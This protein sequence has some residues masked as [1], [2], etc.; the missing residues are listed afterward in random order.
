VGKVEEVKQSASRYRSKKK[1][2]HEK[3]KSNMPKS[4][5][6]LPDSGQKKR[7]EAKIVEEIEAEAVAGTWERRDWPAD[8]FLV[9]QSLVVSNG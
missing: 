7:D 9:A 6:A 5:H 1:N 4:K 8:H 2:E 3:G